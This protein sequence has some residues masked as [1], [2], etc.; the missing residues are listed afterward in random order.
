V[1]TPAHVCVF[2]TA[3]LGV[4]AVAKSLLEGERIDYFTKNEIS[5][6]SY[7]TYNFA[8]G[9]MEIWVRVADAADGRTL[10]KDLTEMPWP[11]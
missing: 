5:Y 2:A 9:P 11:E 7:A 6:G 10:L 8:V 1:D 4:M 3:S